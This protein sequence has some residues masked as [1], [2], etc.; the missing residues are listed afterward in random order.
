MEIKSP[1]AVIKSHRITLK[2]HSRE[3]AAQ[4]FLYVDQDRERLT[5]FLPWVDSTE[6]LEDELNYIE[7]TQSGWHK[8][9][10][11]DYG[12]FR[13]EDSAYLGNCGVHTIKWDHAC[14]ELGYWVLGKF[15]G[16]GYV[17]ESVRALEKVL[18]GIGF[19]RIE[20]R[21]S[22][23]N[24]RSAK[25]PLSCGYTLEGTLRQNQSENQFFRDTL[26]FAKLR[27]DSK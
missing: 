15:E 2:R 11:F 6:T 16:K 27:E 14:C 1:P 5:Q 25:V 8:G 9:T 3:L 10:L 22:S 20:I 21:C 17:S 23:K 24:E 18:F 12:I 7:F 13:N 26:V 19:Q 4:M